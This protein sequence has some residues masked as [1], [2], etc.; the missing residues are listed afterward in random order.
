M[1]D[2]KTYVEFVDYSANKDIPLY[3]YIPF[4]ENLQ[5]LHNLSNDLDA[6]AETT[7]VNYSINMAICYNECEVNGIVKHSDANDLDYH[8]KLEGVLKWQ[9]ALENYARDE[10]A[11]KLLSEMFCLDGVQKYF[12]FDEPKISEEDREYVQWSFDYPWTDGTRRHENFWILWNG[13]E[14]DLQAMHNHYTGEEFDWH[15]QFCDPQPYT[16][17]SLDRCKAPIGKLLN[18]RLPYKEVLETRVEKEKLQ[19][20]DDLL[21]GGSIEELVNVK[22]VFI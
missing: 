6:L 10:I 9:S 20:L 11:S 19:Y 22:M 3:F 16:H 7:D 8:F 2:D 5:E 15:S 13:N 1:H 21:S 12:I 14:D 17:F 18:G 4:S